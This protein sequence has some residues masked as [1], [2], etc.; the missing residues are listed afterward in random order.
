MKATINIEYGSEELEKFV[1]NTGVMLLKKM[2]GSFKIDPNDAP[3]YID[4]IK[5]GFLLAMDGPVQKR[6]SNGVPPQPFGGGPFA[7]PPGYT[8]VPPPWARGTVGDKVQ[9]I[10]DPGHVERCFPI[11]ATRNIEAGIGCC[12]CATYNGTQRTHCRNCGHKLCVIATPPQGEEPS[13][14]GDGG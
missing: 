6:R 5:Q 1:S 8:E 3:Y 10:R 12:T 9:P 2:L 13:P 4:M 11:E 14:V 7:P